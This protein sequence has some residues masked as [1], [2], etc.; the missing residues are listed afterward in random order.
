VDGQN[1]K[2]YVNQVWIKKDYQQLNKIVEI[3]DEKNIEKAPA[4][5]KYEISSPSHGKNIIFAA[6]VSSL[7]LSVPLLAVT[8]IGSVKEAREKLFELFGEF[9]KKALEWMKDGGNSKLL[10]TVFASV[11]S[12]LTA[13]VGFAGAL[14]TMLPPLLNRKTVKD[15]QKEIGTIAKTANERAINEIGFFES[16]VTE[17]KDVSGEKNK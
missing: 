16:L 7:A 2:S 4:P 9:G 10:T 13:A 1:S 17:V 15:A 11:G 6:G 5:E 8:I 3:I 14:M 12:V